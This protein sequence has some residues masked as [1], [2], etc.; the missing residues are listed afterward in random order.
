MMDAIQKTIEIINKAIGRNFPLFVL[1]FIELKTMENILMKIDII[2]TIQRH[3]PNTT[4]KMFIYKRVFL[5][6]SLISFLL[7]LGT[8]FLHSI[9]F[10]L[11]S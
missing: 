9:I 3:T 4:L 1:M 7:S 2:G 10:S 6:F 11:F 5:F 8:L